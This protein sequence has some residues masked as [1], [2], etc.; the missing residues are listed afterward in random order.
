M[1]K[2]IVN[3]A[4]ECRSCK[5]YSKNVKYLIPKNAS[6]TLPLLAQPGQEVQLDYA[7]PLENHRGKNLPSSSYR[8]ILETSFGK[9]H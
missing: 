1:H 4:E 5:G 2:D 6:K 7:G 9:N 3:L 8:L